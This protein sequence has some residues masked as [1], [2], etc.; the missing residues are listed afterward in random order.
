MFAVQFVLI[1]WELFKK[2]LGDV[3]SLKYLGK[4]K[5]MHIIS[6]VHEGICGAH[7]TGNKMKWIVR[8]YYYY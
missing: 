8:R 5:S 4:R 2:A 1:D 3:V 6:E 7:Q